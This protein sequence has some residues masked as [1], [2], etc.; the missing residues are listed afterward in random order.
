MKVIDLRAEKQRVEYLLRKG[1][2][3][4]ILGIGQEKKGECEERIREKH[5]RDR[6]MLKK[7]DSINNALCASDAATYVEVEGNRLSVATARLYLMEMSDGHM[8]EEEECFDGF[9]GRLVPRTRDF[10]CGRNLRKLVYE[11]CT[12]VPTGLG[13]GLGNDMADPLGLSG[14]REEFEEKMFQWENSL[15]KA[16]AVSDA[17]TDIQFSC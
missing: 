10:E 13:Y 2:Y 9:D 14:R 15:R 11:K 7:L 1:Q 5:D 3:Y 4:E 16:V 8:C 6:Q 12:S 17:V